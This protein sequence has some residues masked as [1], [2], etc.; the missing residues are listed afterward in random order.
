MA[1]SASSARTSVSRNRRCPPGVRM[2]PIHPLDAH[3]ATVLGSTRNICAT[4]CGVSSRSVFS[5]VTLPTFAGAPDV[6]PQRTCRPILHQIVSDPQ[7]QPRGDDH[8]RRTGT[9]P[10]SSLRRVACRSPSGAAPVG[11]LI[12]RGLPRG[13]ASGTGVGGCGACRRLLPSVV[14]VRCRP[15]NP[16]TAHLGGRRIWREH[17]VMTVSSCGGGR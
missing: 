2:D 6:V 7:S 12:D 11:G 4:W 16:V 15:R 1:R 9:H 10:R 17:N 8:L 3:R 13:R 5:S 14:I